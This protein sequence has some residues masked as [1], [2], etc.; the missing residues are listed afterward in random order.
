M[1]ARFRPTLRGFHFAL[2]VSGL[3]VVAVVPFHL[4]KVNPERRFVSLDELVKM[5]PERQAHVPV[6]QLNLVCAQGL[7][8]GDGP[9]LNQCQANISLWAK[10]VQSETE[11]HRYRF[12][13]NPAEFENSEGFFKMLMLAVVL[14]EDYHVHYDQKRR[15]TPHVAT[16][17]D[18]FFSDPKSVFLHGL[19]GP[20]RKGTCSSL[21]LLYVAIGRELGYPLKLATT[22]AHLFVRWEG[23]GERFN[24][25]AAGDHGLNRLPDEYYRHWPFEITPA[26]IGSVNETVM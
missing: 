7:D 18:G 4:T 25:E 8:T 10:H 9:D 1:I 3:L 16:A 14:A 2:L 19:L 5:S 11:R 12:I 24:I 23:D 13:R 22:K 26:G 21:P 20:E 6:A 15:S 17:S